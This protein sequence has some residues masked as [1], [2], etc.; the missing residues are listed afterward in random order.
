[1][2]LQPGFIADRDPVATARLPQRLQGKVQGCWIVQD[3][4]FEQTDQDSS[5][6]LSA[7][8]FASGYFHLQPRQGLGRDDRNNIGAATGIGQ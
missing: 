6:G 2:T 3:P 1:M 8:G 7:Q 5:Q 4:V